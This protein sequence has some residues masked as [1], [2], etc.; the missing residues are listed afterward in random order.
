MTSSR[1]LIPGEPRS[2]N[3]RG[4]DV[5]EGNKCRHYASVYDLA[6]RGSLQSCAPTRITCCLEGKS[7]VYNYRI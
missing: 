1:L 6:L 4:E 3:E 5:R 7:Y 2:D